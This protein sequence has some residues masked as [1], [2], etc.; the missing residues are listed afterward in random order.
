[1]SEDEAQVDEEQIEERTWPF[2][3]TLKNPFDFG[4]EHVT[5]LEFREGC[6]GDL[7]GIKVDK[8]GLGLEQLVL[9]TSRLCGKSV[10]LIEKLKGKDGAEALA[11]ARDFFTESLTGGKTL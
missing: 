4:K 11:V 7:K 3:L 5:Q 2:I 6:L 10:G 1:M 8:S 9:L